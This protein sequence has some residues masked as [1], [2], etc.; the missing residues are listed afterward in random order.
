MIALVLIWQ[1]IVGDPLDALALQQTAP[2]DLTVHTAWEHLIAARTAGRVWSVDPNLL[3]SI[4]HHE[5]RYQHGEITPELGGKVSCGVMT[6]EPILDRRECRVATSSILDGY[7]SGARHLRGWLDVCRGNLRCALTGYAGGYYLIYS[8]E[9]E[10]AK[11]CETWGV[12]LRRAAQ[13]RGNS[14]TITAY[15]TSSDNPL[16]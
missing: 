16:L 5:S 12:F 7:L 15:L 6:P 11:A 2:S 8:C 4:A 10:H 14:P 9:R 1:V 3:L 13:I